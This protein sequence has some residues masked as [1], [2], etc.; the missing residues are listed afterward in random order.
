MRRIFGLAAMT[1]L[2]V[3]P[4]LLVH[5]QA[6][7][8]RRAIHLVPTSKAPFSDAV[9]AGNT[10]YLSGR[11]GFDPGSGAIPEDVDSEIRFLLDGF[12]SVLHEA[13]LTMNELVF[14]QV[15]CTDLS[16]YD[17]FNAAYR[18]RISDDFPAR[19]FIGSGPLLRGAHFEM[20]GIAVADR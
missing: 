6:P 8:G 4:W 3:V 2:V 1:S 14:V 9:L 10:L 16:L 19:A 12:E 11:L 20:L 5:A 7:S 18:T 15:F 13:G 17:T